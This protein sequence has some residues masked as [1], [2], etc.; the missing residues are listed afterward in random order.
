LQLYINPDECIE[1]DACVPACPPDAI[2]EEDD[3]I[4]VGFIMKK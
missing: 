1:C 4:A 3:L 2:Y